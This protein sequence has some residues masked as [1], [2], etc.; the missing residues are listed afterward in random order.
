MG[1]WNVII[2]TFSTNMV[3]NP[4]AMGTGNYAAV[5][6][7][8]TVTPT[9]AE[10]YSYFGYR[11]YLTRNAG[12][13]DNSGMTLTLAALSNAIHYVTVRTYGTVSNW[14]WSLDNANFNV[15]TLLS[16]EGNWS[17]YGYQFPAAQANASTTLYLY[18]NAAEAFTW[19]I[20]HIQVEARSSPTTPITGDIQGFT[21]GGYYWNGSAHASSSTRSGQECSGGVVTDLETS[22]NFRVR[23]G[24]GSGMPPL[25]HHVQG[26]ALLPGALFQGTK[27]EP[28]VLDL[29]SAT[30]ANTVAAVS[31][32]RK[33][34]INAVKPDRV[35]EEQPVVFR[36]TAVNANKPVDFR[37]YYDSGMEFQVSG[38]VIDTPVARFI[39]Y[40]PFAYEVHD[41][42]AALTTSTTVANADEIVRKIDGTWYNISTD[43]ASTVEA[44]VRGA[45]GCIF[46][47]GSFT[48]VGD[49]DGDYIVKW[50]PYTSALSSLG[51]GT[52]GNVY[53][54]AAA[55]NGDIYLGGVFA[56]AGGVA[57]TVRI[58]YWDVSASVFAP[59]STGINNDGVLTMAFD[60]S[61]NLYVG[62]TFTDI[63]D[64]NGDYITKWN[65][66][67]FSSLG[68][69]MNGDVYAL[70]CAPNGDIY[71]GGVF[72]L[73][74]GVADTAGIARWDGTQ[75]LPLGTGVAGGLADVYS[76]AI[77]KAGNVYI[78]GNFTTANGVACSNIAMWNGKTFEPLG[79]GTDSSVMALSFDS[80]GLLYAGG[81]FTM[82][83]G[84]S[85]ANRM[86]IW[87]GTT[88]AHFDASLPGAGDVYAF[89]PTQ[90][91]VN[92]RFSATNPLPSG[93][94]SP[95]LYIG[96]SSVGT[97]TVSYLN[98]VTN[99]GSASAYP[100][101][102]IH[103]AEDGTSAVVEWI[104]NENTGDT[105]W[106]NY[107]LLKG[108]TLTIDLTPGNRAIYSNFFGNV[109]R[110]VLRSSDLSSFRLLPSEN[111]ISVFVNPTGAPTIT[112][113]LEYPIT[114]WGSDM[115]AA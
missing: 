2:P 60:Q 94:D 21:A 56:L 26:M 11:H 33:N 100:V 9:G 67:A 62:G 25:T 50:N 101:I 76:I 109:W 4:V 102:N 111:Y 39:C 53:A 37:C 104:K 52:N 28:R 23:Y 95:D 63:T 43:F 64:A 27:V 55:P 75:W 108:E 7:G 71:A 77:D 80:N 68:T 114:H 16:T 105:L 72:A 34:F 1:A 15:P 22:Y 84:V 87:N 61:G 92:S 78:G 65:G 70:A 79:S 51:T 91:Y 103:R 6:A 89:L 45:D 96:Y 115:V 58:A 14:D 85:L 35:G 12:A 74:G 110:A 82:A 3:L 83:G 41:A 93:I 86:A 73:A 88:W 46:I 106:C 69:G 44:L 112:A 81:A 107:S 32:A 29:V 13:V 59:L 48:N 31:A 19:Y 42:S 5:G 38:G 113:W 40:D 18:K 8:A 66:A 17:V 49:G 36:Y 47:G 30:K 20:G 90:S 24:D 54:L 99:P 10:G 57:N 98:T 97:A